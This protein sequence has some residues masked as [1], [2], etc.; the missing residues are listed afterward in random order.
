MRG[1]V[2]LSGSLYESDRWSR[3]LL[4]MSPDAIKLVTETTL[5]IVGCGGT[6]S[7]LALSAAYSKFG[8]LIICDND[9]LEPSNLGRFIFATPDDVGRPKASLVAEY[10]NKHIPETKVAIID[11]KF[12]SDAVLAT[13]AD[14]STVAVGCVDDVRVRVE[15][16]VACRHYGRSLVDLGTGFGRDDAGTIVT[17]GGQVLISRPT[18]PCLMCLGFPHLLNENDYMAGHGSS[19][20]PSL[21]LLNN[22]VAALATGCLLQEVIG[23]SDGHNAISY[24][25]DTI[26]VTAETRSRRLTCPICGEG[27]DLNTASILDDH[28]APWI[29]SANSD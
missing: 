2:H 27:A 4:W 1:D 22:I 5:M 28:T 18:G 6:G 14:P 11:S 23:N 29:A 15:L 8:Q 25:R 16:D 7:L 3:T 17:S 9:I 12:P 19:P 20:Q 21:F 24:S 10:L 26:S 13:L